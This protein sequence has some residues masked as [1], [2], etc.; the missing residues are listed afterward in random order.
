MDWFINFNMHKI[1]IIL[2]WSFTFFVLFL[3]IY[4][5]WLR[6]I[7]N[8]REGKKRKLFS[9]WEEA[10]Y[11]ILEGKQ[12]PREIV[13]SISK[14]DY[15][16]FLNYLEDYLTTLK[17]EDFERISSFITRTELFTC[18]CER[19]KY[20]KSYNRSDAA[21]FLGLARASEAKTILKGGLKDR[22][23][24]V[25]FNCALA[26]A[27]IGAVEIVEEILRQYHYRKKYSL[28]LLLFLFIEFGSKVCPYLLQHLPDERNESFLI[29]MVDLLGHFRYYPA[30]EA[31]LKLLKTTSH[32]EL[33]IRC[34]KAIGR[35]EYIEALPIL[36]E[37]VDDSNWV[38]RSQS[39]I[40]LGKIGDVTIEKKLIKNLEHE[41][42]WVRY[43][44]AEA[45]FNLSEQGEEVLK[46]V[47]T[48][49]Q[50]KKAVT[51]AQVVLTEKEMGA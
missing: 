36:R 22:D 50:N 38:I 34:I 44:S 49:S 9:Q 13:K 23:D 15:S 40:A 3:A 25:V 4:C 29:L 24:S 14:S 21:F 42:W 2:V 47:V 32:K 12:S 46:S 18:L 19:L 8:L 41:K 39:I 16:Y 5:L 17:G 35:I 43:R 20:G 27:K 7:F 51:A 6:L 31:I 37:Y 10:V 45:I 26:L 30:G 28:D 33:K 48:H 1:I 11:N